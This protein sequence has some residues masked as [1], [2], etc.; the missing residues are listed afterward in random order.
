MLG[1]VRKI[2]PLGVA[3]L[4]SAGLVAAA[5]GPFSLQGER[6]DAQPSASGFVALQE[7]PES[8]TWFDLDAA[9][10]EYEAQ[11]RAEEEAARV[12]AERAAAEAARYAGIFPS[13]EHWLRIHQC[14]Q[15]DS[16]TVHGRFGNGMMGGGGLGL[17]D[18]AWVEWGGLQY[19]PHAGTADPLDQMRVA[20]VGYGRH[21]GSPWGCK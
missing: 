20:S 10:A 6:A 1:R 9:V 8:G 18:A 3:L 13:V 7:T 12:E 2:Y 5:A 17:S 4:A 16:W 19:G 11:L 14:E 21:G 15:P